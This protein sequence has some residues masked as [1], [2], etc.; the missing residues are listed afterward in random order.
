MFEVIGDFENLN[1]QPYFIINLIFYTQLVAEVL[2]AII[3][4]YAKNK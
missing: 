1:H 2:E 4:I 3:I